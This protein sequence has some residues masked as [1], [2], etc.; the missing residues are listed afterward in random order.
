MDVEPTSL[1]FSAVQ[2]FPALSNNLRF[3]LNPNVL[4]RSYAMNCSAP[5]LTPTKAKRV[6]R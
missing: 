6:P 4:I 3:C 1:S 5:L 2:G